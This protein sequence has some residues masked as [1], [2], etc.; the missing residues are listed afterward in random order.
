[1]KFIRWQSSQ[2]VWLNNKFKKTSS[3]VFLAFIETSL[4]NEM[5]LGE[6]MRTLKIVYDENERNRLRHAARAIVIKD[7]QILL[8]YET[9]TDTYMIPGGGVENDETYSMACIREVEEETGYIISNPTPALDI[10]EYFSHMIH[11]NHYFI[12]NVKSMGERRLTEG[13]KNNGLEP[14]WVDFNL[15]MD[16]FKSYEDFKTSFIE[17]YG[18]YYR[19]YQALKE[20]VFFM[21]R[22]NPRL[23][24]ESYQ[25]VSIQEAM[26]KEYMLKMLE[27]FGNFAFSRECLACHFS[28]SA[29]ITNKSH[30]KVLLNWHNIYKNWGWLGGHNDLDKDFLGVALK[31]AMEES[32]LKNLK[33]LKEEPISLEILPVTYH[34]KK[35][36]FVSSHVHMNLTYLFEADENDELKIKPDENSGLQWV[37]LDDAI[38]ITNEEDMKPIY[39]K[40]NDK[41]KEMTK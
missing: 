18:L 6:L 19:E 27:A 37:L 22:T 14:R 40:L 28:S 8:S 38:K 39:Q 36:S 15:A 2:L 20:Y 5:H 41:L 25:P 31:E 34:M 30:D 7:N 33:V 11:I 29:W 16:I 13:E 35:N 17:K 9:K 24:I 1:M 10:E 26:D 4:Y 12:A 3:E 32:G 21:K 23:L